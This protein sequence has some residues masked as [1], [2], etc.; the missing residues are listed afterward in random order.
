MRA[1]YRSRHDATHTHCPIV[2]AV[3]RP[4]LL[5]FGLFSPSVCLRSFRHEAEQSIN[6]LMTRV[7]RSP[8]V[9]SSQFYRCRF[10]IDMVALELRCPRRRTATCDIECICYEEWMLAR[11]IH[12]EAAGC[13]PLT[14]MNETRGSHKPL[15]DLRGTEDVPT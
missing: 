15:S 6:Q 10:V 11:R 14:P 5:P 7:A 13:A 4:A 1:A 8:S 9:R 12:P 2:L 3:S